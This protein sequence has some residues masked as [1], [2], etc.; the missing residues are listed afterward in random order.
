LNGSWLPSRGGLN[1]YVGNSTYT[2]ALLPD[3]D[4]DL[5]I[6]AAAMVIRS[7]RP[8]V[9][10]DSADY[11]TIANRILTAE[12][13]KHM[14]DDPGRTLRRKAL[15]VLYFFSPRPVPY[16][17]IGDDTRLVFPGDD[18]VV[19]RALGRPM[20]EVV[21][22]GLWHSAVLILGAVG[23]YNRRHQLR[24]DALLWWIVAT[25][26]VVYAGY[27]PATRYRA[28]ITF[29]FLFSAAVA[30]DS[31]PRS[32]VRRPRSAADACVAVLE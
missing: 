28:P 7:Q 13:L 2:D 16:W 10:V 27:F 23:V 31:V 8:D 15:N 9:S 3:H 25:F 17:T 29:V 12:A 30:L 6:P 32:A 19:E 18:V 11:E 26:V 5:L 22:Y 21:G 20:V 24:E 14:R 1:L 4:V